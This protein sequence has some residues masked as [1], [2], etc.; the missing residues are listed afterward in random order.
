MVL[1]SQIGSPFCLTE[2]GVYSTINIAPKAEVSF[3][4]TSNYDPRLIVEAPILSSCD[5][6][7]SIPCFEATT[8]GYVLIDFIEPF[9]MDMFRILGNG[10]QD[11]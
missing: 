11:Y 6:Q 4:G 3:S 8:D 10:N 1:Y 7:D 9:I 5:D 2:L